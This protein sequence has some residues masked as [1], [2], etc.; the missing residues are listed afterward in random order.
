MNFNNLVK[1][2]N[3]NYLLLFLIVLVGFVLVDCN[4]K[5]FSNMLNT[6]EGN[7]N[8][9]GA[10]APHTCGRPFT[11]PESNPTKSAKELFVKMKNNTKNDNDSINPL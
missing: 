4:T 3:K 1:S 7:S 11:A 5:M 9:N 8:N 10:K 2:V 6:V